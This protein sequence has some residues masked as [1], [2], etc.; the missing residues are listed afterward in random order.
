MKF[1]AYARPFPDQEAI[2][3]TIEADSLEE[4]WEKARTDLTTAAATMQRFIDQ[5]GGKAPEDYNLELV[6][7]VPVH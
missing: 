6:D 1:I 2:P 4:A 3:R 5:I 7:V